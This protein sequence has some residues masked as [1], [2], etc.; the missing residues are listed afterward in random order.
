MATLSPPSVSRARA[1]AL[2]ADAGPAGQV[3]RNRGR[4]AAAVVLMV[5]SGW[6]A[7]VVFLSV[8]G[9]REVLSVARPVERYA[10]LTADDLAVVRV[11]ADSD[12]EVVSA[13]R[14]DDL[15]GR[16]TEVEL[17]EGSLLSMGH[18]FDPD[19]R[20]VG[21]NESVVG[22]LLA[23]TD[24][25][26]LLEQGAEVEVIARPAAGGDAGPLKVGGWV[27]DVADTDT[28]GQDGRRV[29]LVV[30]RDD[31]GAISS[32]ASDRRVSVVVVGGA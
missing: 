27:L 21:E 10:E 28:A 20:P 11:A 5:L 22:A 7:A 14:L 18:L 2:G 29:S 6:L 8:G 1:N 15:V 4:I 24:A 32:A 31:A 23:S 30:P 16:Y 25:P 3:R 17:T 19:D 26:S 13:D 9:R 12:V